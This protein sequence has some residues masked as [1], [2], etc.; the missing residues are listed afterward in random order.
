MRIILFYIS[1]TIQLDG[2]SLILAMSLRRIEK[3]I[4]KQ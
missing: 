4:E 2:D 1:V 3:H